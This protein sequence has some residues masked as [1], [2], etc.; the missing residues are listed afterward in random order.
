MSRRI[1]EENFAIG[2]HG[3]DGGGTALYQEFELLFGGAPSGD[4][5]HFA[6]ITSRHGQ[7]QQSGRSQGQ[8]NEDVAR[9]LHVERERIQPVGEECTK[10]RGKNHLPPVQDGS[11]KDHREHVEKSESSVDL[12]FAVSECDRADKNRRKGESGART[13]LQDAANHR[14]VTHSIGRR[15]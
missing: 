1:G 13:P 3:E 2:G 14:Y 9:N 4:T 7:G 10:E 5:L 15:F 11:E 12:Y 8:K 6:A